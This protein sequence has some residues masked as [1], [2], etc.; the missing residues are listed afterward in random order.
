MKKNLYFSHDCNAM[1][2]NKIDDL[3]AAYGMEGYGVFWGIVEAL[4]REPGFS[5]PLTKRKADSLK[6]AMNPS[7]DMMKFIK[8][9]IDFDLFKT[10]GDK[11]WSE[12]LRERL[13]VVSEL[14]E[15]RRDAANA[16]WGKE[17][18][19]QGEETLPKPEEMDKAVD[20]IDP[21][22]RKVVIAYESQIGL[23]PNG[24]ALEKLLSYYEDLG[25]DTM[26]VAINETNKA[27][28]RNPWQYLNKILEDYIARGVKSE[29][30]AKA[31]AVEFESK[32]KGWNGNNA[33]QKGQQAPQNEEEVR[34]L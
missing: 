10:D 22:W 9:C 32:R 8:D 21:G 3:R 12:S 18:A 2:D 27:Q 30:M 19:K 26:V 29:E 14:S 6:V 33:S 4:S 31:N 11:F 17:K 16:R 25:A 1:G 23:L 15:K 7:F 28:P 5:L 20:S 13:S 24:N 34:W